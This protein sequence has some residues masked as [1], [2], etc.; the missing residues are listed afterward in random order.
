MKT[1]RF[2]EEQMVKILREADRTPVAATS[3]LRASGASLRAVAQFGK[4]YSTPPSRSL[5]TIRTCD[6]WSYTIR[7]SGFTGDAG[8]GRPS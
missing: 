5:P 4:P 1:S 7:R 6:V 8:S 3:N 2:S